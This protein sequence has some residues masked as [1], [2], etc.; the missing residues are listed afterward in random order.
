MSDLGQRY[1]TYEALGFYRRELSQDRVFRYTIGGHG[2]VSERKLWGVDRSLLRPN[3]SDIQFFGTL[4]GALDRA[5]G[6]FGYFFGGGWA[7]GFVEN[8]NARYTYQSV[9]QYAAASL[10]DSIQVTWRVGENPTDTR[11][12]VFREIV[13]GE[14]GIP[15]NIPDGQ[16]VLVKKTLV[17]GVDI[18][19]FAELA[20]IDKL[21]V[22][23]DL[24]LRR[25]DQE[26]NSGTYNSPAELEAAQERL[27]QNRKQWNGWLRNGIN[28]ISFDGLFQEL[29]GLR[30]SLTLEQY[31]GRV[32]DPS[33]LKAAALSER[34]ACLKEK[35]DGREALQTR[36]NHLE[37][38]GSRSTAGRRCQCRRGR[39]AAR[40]HPSHVLSVAQGVRRD[41]GRSGQTAEGS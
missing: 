24:E 22:V 6:I 34:M 36:G 10:G 23:H 38:A 39:A 1:T 15:D 5:Q 35:S 4:T 31:Q 14:E 37:A 9:E 17:V 25:G 16:V 7:F 19:V 18:P 2:N 8:E 41:E 12:T 21:G 40:C 11:K 20:P 26:F 13:H 30:S 33:P 27:D 3:S 32:A 29:K 28:A